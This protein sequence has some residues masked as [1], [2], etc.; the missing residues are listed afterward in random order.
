MS[1]PHGDTLGIVFSFLSTFEILHGVLSEPGL[2][3]CFEDVGTLL[4]THT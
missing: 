1:F 4:G 3:V 2:D